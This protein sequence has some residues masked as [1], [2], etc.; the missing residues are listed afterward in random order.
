MHVLIKKFTDDYDYIEYHK[1]YI[2]G[3]LEY[4]AGRVEPEDAMI[5]RDLLGADELVTFMQKAYD[6]AKDG[7][8]LEIEVVEVY[9]EEEFWE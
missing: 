9:S 3:E 7:E 1:L 6:A 4:S 2:D 8:D 5:G